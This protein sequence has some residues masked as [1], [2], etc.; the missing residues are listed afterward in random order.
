MVTWRIKLN[1]DVVGETAYVHKVGDIIEFPNGRGKYRIVVVNVWDF[2]Y[3]VE[4][5]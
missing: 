4:E 1:G 5:D 2:I 3:H